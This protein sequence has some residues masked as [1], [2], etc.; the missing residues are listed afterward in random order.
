MKAIR[1]IGLLL[2]IGSATA[3]AQPPVNIAD[4]TPRPAEGKA[5]PWERAVEKDWVD[6]RFWSMDTGPTFDA[7]FAIRD[8]LRRQLVYKGTAIRVGDHGEGAWLFDRCQ[9]R[10]AAGWRKR[11]NSVRR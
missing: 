11:P 9:M 3:L 1:I 10:W 6:A 5:E 7:T 2:A 8:S 4:W